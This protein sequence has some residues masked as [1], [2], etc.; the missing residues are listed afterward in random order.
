ME[1]VPTNANDSTTGGCYAAKP[2]QADLGAEFVT[3]IRDVSREHG[4]DSG[5]WVTLT[6]TYG[7]FHVISQVEG[8]AEWI[9]SQQELAASVPGS[10]RRTILIQLP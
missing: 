9:D 7:A 1:P 2:G 4:H 8:T 3:R 6:G 10:G 5:A